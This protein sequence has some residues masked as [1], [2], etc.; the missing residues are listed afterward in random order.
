MKRLELG[1][2]DWVILAELLALVACALAP[3]VREVGFRRQAARLAHEIQLV[4]DAARTEHG[5]SGAWPEDGA[6]G[7]FPASLKAHLPRGFTFDRGAYRLDWDH[8]NL[9]DGPGAAWATSEFVV[10]SVVARDP[11]LTNAA[12]ERLAGRQIRFTLGNRT[13]F[14][15]PEV[16][17]SSP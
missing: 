7:R 17:A 12:G 14:V 6:A 5:K 4:G 8:W 1:T 16:G 3:V 13:T 10:V 9:S 11:R 2:L 15:L